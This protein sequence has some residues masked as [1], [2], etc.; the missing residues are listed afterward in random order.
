M[1][2]CVVCMQCVCVSMTE[3]KS[4]FAPQYLMALGS[5]T[6]VAKNHRNVLFKVYCSKTSYCGYQGNG[7]VVVVR[8]GGGVGGGWKEKRKQTMQI[9]TR[10]EL[11]FL[12]KPENKPEAAKAKTDVVIFLFV[13]SFHFSILSRPIKVATPTLCLMSSSTQRW[14]VVMESTTMLSRGPQAVDTATSYFSSIAPKSPCV[15]NNMAHTVRL[16]TL[17]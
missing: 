4:S 1:C 9:S 5:L 13:C 3:S 14:A 7:L 8:G 15:E 10:I 11:W 16:Q 17:G 2:M 12:L 6:C